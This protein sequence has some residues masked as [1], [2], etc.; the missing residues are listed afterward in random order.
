MQYIIC[1]QLLNC[2][3]HEMVAE[4]QQTVLQ[5]GCAEPKF[6]GDQIQALLQVITTFM[7]VAYHC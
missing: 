5:G 6:E 3:S 2:G 4:S 1:P 7:H